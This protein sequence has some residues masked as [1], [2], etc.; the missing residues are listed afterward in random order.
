MTDYLE[1]TEST[2]VLVKLTPDQA[3][4]LRNLSRSLA[5]RRTWWGALPTEEIKEADVIRIVHAAGDQYRI[6]VR[7]AIGTIALGDLTL[8]IGPKIPLDH[9][10]YIAAHSLELDSREANQATTL[11]SGILFH[12][13]VARWLVSRAVQV[14]RGGLSTDYEATRDSLRYVRGRIDTTKTSVNFSRG[15]PVIESEF[16][17]RTNNSPENR[18]LRS[19]I[20]MLDT[21]RLEEDELK[22]SASKLRKALAFVEEANQHD[23]R[24]PLRSFPT[25]YRQA[26]DLAISVIRHSGRDLSAGNRASS[27]FLLRTPNLMEDGIRSI[28]RQAL[29][30]VPVS[31]G[32]RVLHPTSLTSNP[33]ILL[34]RPPKTADVKYKYFGSMWNRA[35]LAQGVFFAESYSSTQGAVIGFSNGAH[36]LPEVPVGRITIS[37]LFWDVAEGTTPQESAARL[38]RSVGEW[39]PVEDRSLVLA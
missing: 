13:L 35:D 26:V 11:A 21:S 24:L 19:A 2:E 25:R 14:L 30:P 9:F 34:S 12:D 10:A 3:R 32:G 20:N 17:E 1:I 15:L 28:I 22:A 37:P 31:R 23:L 39:L 29:A 6:S 18:I 5:S 16:E 33:D 7:N 36:T 4:R 8:L 27:S 38:I